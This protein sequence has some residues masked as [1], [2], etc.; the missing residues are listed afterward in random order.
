MALLRKLINSG[1]GPKLMYL[2]RAV[3]IT[4]Q[5]ERDWQRA[6]E[7]PSKKE[8]ALITRQRRKRARLAVIAGN[9]A[10]ASPKHISK[11]KRPK[12]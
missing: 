1:R 2:N 3:R 11:R 10:A 7:N 8:L 12:S 9:A 4:A 6:R 5:A